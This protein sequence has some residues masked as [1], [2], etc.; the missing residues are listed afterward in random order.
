MTRAD[1]PRQSIGLPA[2]GLKTHA[3]LGV[4]AD[5]PGMNPQRIASA[6]GGASKKAMHSFC[7]GAQKKL[8]VE[9]NQSGKP[10][11]YSPNVAACPQ[12]P[13]GEAL[14]FPLS[15]RRRFLFPFI[16][17]RIARRA[18]RAPPPPAR[19]S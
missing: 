1:A 10:G 11:L 8:R 15:L 14:P 3:D 9:G 7:A 6:R 18:R 13:G 2:S 16:C 5:E 4:S 12:R 17:F 19:T